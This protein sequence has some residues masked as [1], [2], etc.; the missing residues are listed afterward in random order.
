MKSIFRYR[1]DR[2]CEGNV[3]YLFMNDV[4]FITIG[5]SMFGITRK[6]PIY[7]TKHIKVEQEKKKISSWGWGKL[8][9]YCTTS[10]NPNYKLTPIYK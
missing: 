10:L 4:P 5:H 2:L 8:C 6:G 7:T 3:F 9:F 1:S